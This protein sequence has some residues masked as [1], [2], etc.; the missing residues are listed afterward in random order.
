[1]AHTNLTENNNL[2]YVNT[3]SSHP[4]QIIKQLSTSTAKRFSKNPSSIELFN[5]VN[6]EYEIA[7]ENS[8]CHCI[9]L[10]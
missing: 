3:S 1:M 2:F 10:N 8:G 4:S 9:K 5:S 6:I 7:L